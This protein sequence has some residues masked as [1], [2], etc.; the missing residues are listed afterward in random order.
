MFVLPVANGKSHILFPD[1]VIS[2]FKSALRRFPSQTLNQGKY[3]KGSH[4]QLLLLLL[5]PTESDQLN[6]TETG[7]AVFR[8]YARTGG[9][10]VT[11]QSF[12][13]GGSASKSNLLPFYI[14][15][16]AE[17]VNPFNIPI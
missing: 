8:P 9:G 6:Y 7:L 16:L 2:I 13:R 3:S 15:F 1:E 17:K 11:Q 4:C 5:L 10:G 14:L 12:K